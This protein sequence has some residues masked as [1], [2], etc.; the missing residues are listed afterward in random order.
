MKE[1]LSKSLN[2]P[3]KFNLIGEKNKK[4]KQIFVKKL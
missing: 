4:M 2:I 1:I 3:L